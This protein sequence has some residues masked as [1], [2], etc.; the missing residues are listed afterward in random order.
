MS[1][2]VTTGARDTLV[3][4]GMRRVRFERGLTLDEVARLLG[5]DRSKVSRI[6]NGK[7]R[8]PAAEV[9]ADMLGVPVIYLLMPCPQCR[10]DPAP[11]FLCLRCGTSAAH[12]SV[13]KVR[14]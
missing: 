10:Y 9:V 3:A 5:C 7:R 6:E 2:R 14:A 12:T 1:R 11:G 8:A 13:E 4:R